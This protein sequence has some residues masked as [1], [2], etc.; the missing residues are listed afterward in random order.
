MN[1]SGATS[2]YDGAGAPSGRFGHGMAPGHKARTGPIFCPI[3]VIRMA[4]PSVPVGDEVLADVREALA[5]IVKEAFRA[6]GVPWT[7]C[8]AEWRGEQVVIAIPPDVPAEML[9]DDLVAPLRAGV[10]RHNR[11]SSEMAKIRLRMAV[12]VGRVVFSRLGI[13]GVAVG[14]TMAF[15]DAPAFVREFDRHSVELGLVTSDYL[16]EE[17]IRYG[18]GLIE[19]AAYE[20]IKVLTGQEQ[21]CAWMYFPG[22]SPNPLRS[23]PDARDVAL[24]RSHGRGRPAPEQPAADP[25]AARRPASD[26]RDA[27]ERPQD[28]QAGSAHGP[29]GAAGDDGSPAGRRGPAVPPADAATWRVA[30]DGQPRPADR[31]AAWRRGRTWAGA[32]RR[33]R[34]PAVPSRSARLAQVAPAGR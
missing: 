20:E 17:V 2:A 33:A 5:G 15:L 34:W 23:A 25:P 10:R 7:S 19:P 29:A 14:R 6:A 9:L 18:P 24:S 28:R 31:A 16:F 27:P 11:L 12:H 4:P 13:T 30:P 3:V 32:W 21:M 8:H 1:V 26:R 22:R